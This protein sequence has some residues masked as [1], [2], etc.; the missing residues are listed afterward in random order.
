LV[1]HAETGAENMPQ[2]SAPAHSAANTFF[3]IVFPPFQLNM[4]KHSPYLRPIMPEFS[5]GKVGFPPSLS[6]YKMDEK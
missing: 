4:Q 2:N 1:S 5:G 3:F 6:Y